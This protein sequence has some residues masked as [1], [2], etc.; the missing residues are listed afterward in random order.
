[1][2]FERK[3]VIP[4]TIYNFINQGK[5]AHTSPMGLFTHTIKFKHTYL[6]VVYLNA[7]VQ[8]TFYNSPQFCLRKEIKL[9]NPIILNILKFPF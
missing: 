3:L 7:E 9:K 6:R 4:K 5:R 1:M 8:L 2:E